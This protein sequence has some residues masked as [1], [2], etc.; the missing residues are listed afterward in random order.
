MA[1]VLDYFEVDFSH[2]VRMETPVQ[3]F[4]RTGVEIKVISRLHLDFSSKA[5][6][7]S[8][9]LDQ[10]Y[11]PDELIELIDQLDGLWTRGWPAPI[12]IL[13]PAAKLYAAGELKIENNPFSVTST[14]PG[15]SGTRH[16]E[17]HFSGRIYLYL[18]AD[19]TPEQQTK[20]KSSIKNNNLDPQFRGATYA[21]K[22]E[23]F[24]KPLAFISH[25]S[26]DKPTIARPIALGLQSNLV[27]VWYDEFSLPVGAK[28][29]E[30]IEKG[31][32]E[33]KKCILV[34]TKN[35]I[36]NDGWTKAEFDSV[37]TKEIFEKGN[38]L[39]PV[40]HEVTAREVYEYSPWLANIKAVN[41]SEG[42]K[43]VIRKLQREIEG[44][45]A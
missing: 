10:V 24:Q 15:C 7:A 5:L 26:R 18:D 25:D 42:A 2:T 13:L 23:H 8:F 38:I 34:V 17:L 12:N 31:I 21:K 19:I 1:K 35:F 27:P 29:R 11:P 30:S 40:W 43:E 4:T 22:R 16:D 28:L 44:E 41:W 36:G 37:F 39:L 3:L 32:K 6:F 9:Y 20:I 14:F 33:S 45:G